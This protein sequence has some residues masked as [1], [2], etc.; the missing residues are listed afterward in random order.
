M[1]NTSV[2]VF[3]FH[4][5]KKVQLFS[6]IVKLFVIVKQYRISADYHGFAF[7]VFMV[8]F[9]LKMASA[10][11]LYLLEFSTMTDQGL[12]EWLLRKSYLRRKY[13]NGESFQ[14]SGQA[15]RI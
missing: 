7:L 12:Q 9:V 1:R 15:G 3:L 2:P 14:C 13:G 8:S 6:V 5:I 10:I 4:E 11:D